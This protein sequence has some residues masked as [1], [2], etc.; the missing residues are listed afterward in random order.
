[1]KRNY[2]IPE[3]SIIET[4]TSSLMV[5]YSIDNISPSKSI[6]TDYTTVI[7]GGIIGDEVSSG[8][9]SGDAKNNNWSFDEE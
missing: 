6:N 8:S 1:M 3:S 4:K 9:I 2:E 5:H 7:N